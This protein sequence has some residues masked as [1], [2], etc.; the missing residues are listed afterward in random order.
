M[1]TILG[2]GLE[3]AVGKFLE[4]KGFMLTSASECSKER[5][6]E[7]TAPRSHEVVVFGAESRLGPGTVLMLREKGIAVPA[8]QVL[9]GS[10]GLAWSS[11]CVAFLDA[12]GD[13]VLP[14]PT[15]PAEMAYAVA[16]VLRRASL[17]REEVYRFERDRQSLEVNVT[18]AAFIVNGLHVVLPKS[19]MLLLTALARTTGILSYKEISRSLYDSRSM[20]NQIEVCVCKIRSHLQSART[21]LVTHPKM[22]YELIGRQT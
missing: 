8:I 7:L 5:L 12:G 14:V 19:E 21:L 17:T 6:C 11:R 4:Q 18:R 20:P 22:G 10:R 16:S 13:N 1:S 9:Q 3:P 2:V 15:E